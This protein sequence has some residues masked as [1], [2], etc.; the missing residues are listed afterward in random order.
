[1]FPW[2]HHFTF[3]FLTFFFAPVLIIKNHQADAFLRKKICNWNYLLFNVRVLSFQT[4]VMAPFQRCE[5]DESIAKQIF[6]PDNHHLMHFVEKRTCS[7][8][9]WEK[10]CGGEHW[11]AT[12]CF[13]LPI[14]FLAYKV[15]W[16][17]RNTKLWGVARFKGKCLMMGRGGEIM[18]C[19]FW[20]YD[21]SFGVPTLP[22]CWSLSHERFST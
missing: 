5:Q 21:H 7:K 9:Q 11:C 13:F 6:Q 20:V 19:G 14:F 1:M 18:D 3:V 8:G 22:T 2:D 17:F 10:G 15:L 4:W 16:K 12:C